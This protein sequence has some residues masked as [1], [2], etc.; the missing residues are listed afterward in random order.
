MVR[1]LHPSAPFVF[2]GYI[3][4]IVPLT[5]TNGDKDWIQL[6]TIRNIIQVYSMV[7]VGAWAYGWLW[8]YPEEGSTV[9]VESPG[10]TKADPLLLS[11]I[12]V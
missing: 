10:L 6:V 9:I 5:K 1:A 8:R 11:N 4:K 2:F 3:I 12:H 7:T